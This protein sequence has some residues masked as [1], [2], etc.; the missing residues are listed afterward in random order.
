MNLMAGFAARLP[1][2]LPSPFIVRRPAVPLP[3]LSPRLQLARAA[4]VLVSVLSVSLVVELLVMSPLQHRAAQQRAF[5][6]F[7]GALAQGTAPVGPTDQAGRELSAGA[8]VAYLEIP[9]IGVGQVVGEG[10]SGGDLFAGPGHRR[11]T[12]LPGQG[13]VSVV[14]GRQAAFGG[15]FARIDELRRGSV[16]RVTTGQ[17]VFTYKVTGGRRAG[18]PAPG[19]VPAGSGRLL[20]VTAGGRPFMPSG[21]LRVDAELTTP[22]LPGPARLVGSN[23]LPPSERIMGADTSTLWALALWLQGLI[24][25]ILGAVYA[26]HRWSRAKAWVVFLPPL[27]FVGLGGASEAA[28]LLPNLL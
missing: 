4:L 6:Q 21:V 13:G 2:R 5:D 9:S 1:I 16:V 8:A 24:V 11:D 27:L 3:R 10:T 25:V 15:P 12:P 18:D 7:R 28:R 26:W 19:A 14:M 17:G 22:A 20:L 23:A